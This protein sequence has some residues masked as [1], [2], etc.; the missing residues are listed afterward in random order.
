[1]AVLLT[2]LTMPAVAQNNSKTLK[3]TD[4]ATYAITGNMQS[5]VTGE[6]TEYELLNPQG[7]NS[8]KGYLT[9]RREAHHYGTLV[10]GEQVTFSLQDA[11]TERPNKFR[12]EMV[13]W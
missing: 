8:R 1:M 4:E 2:A 3:N 11:K 12:G 13:F 6:Q 9:F 7:S 10:E 5:T